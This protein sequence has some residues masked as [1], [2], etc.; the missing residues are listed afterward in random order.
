MTPSSRQEQVQAL[1]HGVDVL[2]IGGGITGA[3][4][5]HRLAVGRQ[6]HIQLH[7]VSTQLHRPP[8]GGQ[9]VLR[10][11]I[12]GSAMGDDGGTVPQRRRGHQ[13]GTN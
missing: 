10:G 13:S 6:L 2:V 7:P 9:G 1:Q 12:G 4:D 11:L 8:E 3:V 5:D